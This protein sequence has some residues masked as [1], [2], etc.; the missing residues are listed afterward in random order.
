M[1]YAWFMARQFQ[2]SFPDQGMIFSLSRK[3]SDFSKDGAPNVAA[4]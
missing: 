3:L 2:K 4:P 1:V